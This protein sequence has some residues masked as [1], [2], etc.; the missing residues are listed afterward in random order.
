MPFFNSM[1]T[2]RTPTP[3]PSSEWRSGQLP[4]T[5]LLTLRC[6]QTCLMVQDQMDTADLGNLD[7]KEQ[8]AH[9]DLT[10]QTPE[11]SSGLAVRGLKEEAPYVGF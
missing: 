4:V 11:G 1:K 10:L 3:F 5:P 7:T 9:A 8:K 6:C 2:A